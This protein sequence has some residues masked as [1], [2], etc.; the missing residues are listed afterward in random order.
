[1]KKI[2]YCMLVPTQDKI[3]GESSTQNAVASKEYLPT[4]SPCCTN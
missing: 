3:Q 4:R 2:S 1:M